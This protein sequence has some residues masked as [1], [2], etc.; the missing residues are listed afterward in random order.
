M[1]GGLIHQGVQVLAHATFKLSAWQA[2]NVIQVVLLIWAVVAVCLSLLSLL[3]HAHGVNRWIVHAGAVA[4]ALIV[5][6]LIVR[7]GPS[8]AGSPLL[9]L[10]HGAWL[11]LL[12]AAAILAGGAIESIAS[13]PRARIK[14]PAPV[15]AAPDGGAV[16]SNAGPG[17]GSPAGSLTVAPAGAA[18]PPSA[19][20][21]LYGH[22]VS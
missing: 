9:Q 21:W 19:D 14:V 22:R 16:P 17:G 4:C 3:G 11:G 2:F 8:F 20:R 10:E 7:P 1:F 5:F 12:A 15:P 13:G 6:R 18:S